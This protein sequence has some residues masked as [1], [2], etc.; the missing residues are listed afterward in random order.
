[1]ITYG[2]LPPLTGGLGARVFYAESLDLEK[3]KVI[4]WDFA[5]GD[6]RP[7]MDV[8]TLLLAENRIQ[9]D[10]DGGALYGQK[11]PSGGMQL[12]HL[13]AGEWRIVD[14]VTADVDM[15]YLLSPSGDQIFAYGSRGVAVDSTSTLPQKRE[16][17]LTHIGFSDSIWH[18]VRLDTLETPG[19]YPEAGWD[20]E[21]ISWDPADSNRISP[22]QAVAWTVRSIRR[23][24][25]VLPPQP[26][27]LFSAEDRGP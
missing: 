14:P 6:R 19:F 20:W 23:P 2:T 25:L 8:T 21:V 13:H 16:F 9:L 7:V 18:Q 27:I 26:A 17:W 11:L 24:A 12:H 22:S 15:D 1:M 5:T 10:R 4:A 3:S